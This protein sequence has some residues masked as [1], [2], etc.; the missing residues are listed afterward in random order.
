MLNMLAT[1][2]ANAKDQ[3]VL[4]FCH[5]ITKITQPQTIRHKPLPTA[6]QR[7]C[8]AIVAKQVKKK[9]GKAI[10]GWAIWEVRG[11]YLEAE[12]HCVWQN[13][14]GKL[15]N[16]TPYPIE[17]QHIT[18]LPHASKPYEGKQVDSIRQALIENPDLDELLLLMRQ[19]FL[20]ENEGDLATQHGE[21]R[22]SA[23]QTVRYEAIERQ[24]FHAVL[25]LTGRLP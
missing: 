20:I 2:A 22:L 9:G 4:E 7:D 5:S 19:K 6:A 16:I 15:I 10:N 17:S 24:I 13:K 23:E 18:F 1:A 8:F 21:I 14:A 11:L 12:F 3:H 25:R